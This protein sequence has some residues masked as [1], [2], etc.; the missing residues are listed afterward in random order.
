MVMRRSS[1]RRPDVVRQRSDGLDRAREVLDPGVRIAPRQRL[2]DGAREGLLGE[3][4]ERAPVEAAARQRRLQRRGLLGREGGGL[5]C[6]ASGGRVQP[7]VRFQWPMVGAG[8]P[9][10]APISS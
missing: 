2:E 6:S 8:T 10:A 4:Q 9:T 1:G 5:R 7:S 3:A